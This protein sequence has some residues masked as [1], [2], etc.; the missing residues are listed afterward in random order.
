M[1]SSRQHQAQKVGQEGNIEPVALDLALDGAAAL[2]KL[3]RTSA[4]EAIEQTLWKHLLAH[5]SRARVWRSSAE[6]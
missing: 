6:A 3:S 5:S 4:S 2:A 1:Q